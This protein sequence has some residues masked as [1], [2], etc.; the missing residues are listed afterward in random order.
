[1]LLLAGT[2]VSQA[3]NA[4]SEKQAAEQAQENRL[5]DYLSQMTTLVLDRN[6]LGQRATTTAELR[7]VREVARAQTVTALNG[8]DGPRKRFVITFLYEQGLISGLDPLVSLSTA[9]LRAADLGDAELFGAN[10]EGATLSGVNFY[11]TRLT[12]ARLNEADL[13]R[14]DL[15]NALLVDAKLN[16]AD[17]RLARLNSAQLSNASLF[18]ADLRSAS[19]RDARLAGANLISADLR[20]ADLTRADLTGANLT[21]ALLNPSVPDDSA[22]ASTVLAGV[23]WLRTV[24]PDGTLSDDH[25][26]TCD[27]HMSPQ[28]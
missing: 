9:N 22:T 10:L 2:F 25:A 13:Q 20:G 5:K 14:A 24:C 17:L 15:G 1:V 18:D 16:K 28:E 26:G 21:D 7:M 11:G 4:A 6:L 19:L 8:M 12:F 27:G 23:T 3:V